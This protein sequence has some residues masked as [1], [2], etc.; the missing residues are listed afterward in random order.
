MLFHTCCGLTR[1]DGSR[2][3]STDRPMGFIQQKVD[4]TYKCRQAD[5]ARA[6]AICCCHRRHGSDHWTQEPELSAPP[7]PAGI[8]MHPSHHLPAAG[9]VCSIT[10]RHRL[11]S[12]CAPGTRL[13]YVWLSAPLGST[14]DVIW[15]RVRMHT[16]AR[17]AP[18]RA[19][20]C[21][22]VALAMHRSCAE[23]CCS[24]GNGTSAP[25]RL[26]RLDGAA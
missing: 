10:A 22:Q 25:A 15:V 3:S 14:S 20:R 26:F 9:D 12:S 4:N 18:A 13:L 16:T 23:S 5:W 1:R 2:Q 11:T 24:V 8:D 17:P 7:G 19:H 21:D 6:R